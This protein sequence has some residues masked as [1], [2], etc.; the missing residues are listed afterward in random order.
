MFTNRRRIS[1][2]MVVWY[3]HNENRNKE[4]AVSVNLYLFETSL[5]IHIKPNP[6]QAFAMFFGVSSF[7]SQQNNKLNIY[8]QR[9]KKT[10]DTRH[11][12]LFA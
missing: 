11:I 10:N 2:L 9:Y 6:S 12:M 7:V 1:L 5:I 3:V 4:K 8:M